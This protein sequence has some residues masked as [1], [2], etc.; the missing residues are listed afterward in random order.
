VGAVELL[1]QEHAMHYGLDVVNLGDYADPRLI[2]RVA[3][4]AEAASWDGLFMWDHLGFVW[5]APSGDPWISLAAVATATERLILG[6]AVTPLPR[7]RPHVVANAAATLDVLSAGRFILGVGLGGVPEEFGAFGEPT[8]SLERAS[9]LDEGLE[10]V[11]RL[12]S[13]ETVIHQ[14]RHYRVDGVTLAPLPVQQHRIPIWVGGESRPALRRA[15]RWDGWVAGG[16]DENCEVVL[17]PADLSESS[18]YIA[19]QR[20]TATPF[21]VA[22]TGCSVP[23]DASLV[24]RYAAAGATWWLESIHGYRGSVDDMLARIK[25]GPPA[26]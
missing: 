4:A 11:A 17:P 14:G 2:V 23:G 6:T 7:R 21:D 25:A 15:A 19:E 10:V 8:D 5:G 16:I 12:W 22:V 18:A 20:A 24:R 26:I 3:Q 13:G 1:M 9:M